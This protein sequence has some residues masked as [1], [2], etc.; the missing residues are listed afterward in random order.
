MN[1]SDEED[2][3]GSQMAA[4]ESEDEGIYPFRRNKNC[5]YYK[6]S[7]LTQFNLPR[8][9]TINQNVSFIFSLS[10]SDSEIGRGKIVLEKTVVP[11]HD[12]VTILHQ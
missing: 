2:L 9:T 12:I 10:S 5:D 3:Q 1:S 11:I 7:F 6:V 4:S 8:Y